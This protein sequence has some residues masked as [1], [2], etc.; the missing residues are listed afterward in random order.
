MASWLRC[1]VSPGQFTGE[2]AIKGKLHNSADFSLFAPVEYVKVESAPG[3]DKCVDGTISVN[4]LDSQND[5]VLVSLPQ[6]TFENGRTITVKKDQ[7]G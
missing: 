7:M 1:K 2:F 3:Q 6:P 4:I 5:L